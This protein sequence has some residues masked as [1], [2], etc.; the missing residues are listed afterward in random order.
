MDED[1]PSSRKTDKD[2]KAM[3]RQ[4]IIRGIQNKPSVRYPVFNR[5]YWQR[6]KFW[7]QC[8]WA[9][10]EIGRIITANGNVNFCSFPW[11]QFENSSQNLKYTYHLIPL[12]KLASRSGTC[13]KYYIFKDILGSNWKQLKCSFLGA[14]INKWWYI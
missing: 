4:F 13:V 9:Y 6:N 8:F 5:S 14:W 7:K 11:D 12:Q 10:R 1:E 2:M 3:N